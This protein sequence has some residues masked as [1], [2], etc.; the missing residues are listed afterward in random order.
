M[1]GRGPLVDRTANRNASRC[2]QRTGIYGGR[3]VGV[4]LGMSLDTMKTRAEGPEGS[5]ESEANYLRRLGDEYHRA[6]VVVAA[7]EADGWTVTLVL[8]FLDAQNPAVRTPA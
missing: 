7:M 1:G 5:W 4:H 3:E 6:A 2:W 8:S